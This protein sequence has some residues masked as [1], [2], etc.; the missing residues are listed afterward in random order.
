MLRFLKLAALEL[1]LLTSCS[2]SCHEVSCGSALIVE[3]AP[4]SGFADGEY[5]VELVAPEGTESCHFVI[6]GGAATTSTC[7]PGE[8]SLDR[9]ELPTFMLVRY[10]TS[11]YA[12]TVTVTVSRDGMQ[13]VTQDFMPEYEDV[14]VDAQACGGPCT[15]AQVSVAM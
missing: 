6:S 7:I 8:A 3:L 4:E 13:L 5:D 2:D 15:A 14:S 12:E 1:V 11:Y 10:G 9:S